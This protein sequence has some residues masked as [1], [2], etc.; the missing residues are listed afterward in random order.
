M[1]KSPLDDLSQLDGWL[2]TRVWGRMSSL[3]VGPYLKQRNADGVGATGTAQE[4]SPGC[5]EMSHFRVSGNRRNKATAGGGRPLFI[6]LAKQSHRR[7]GL[8][9]FMKSLPVP[10]GGPWWR[11]TLVSDNLLRSQTWSESGREPVPCCRD[12]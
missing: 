2:H 12:H 1:R 5:H 9:T 10:R 4:R 7:R 6:D 3:K 11:W 8:T